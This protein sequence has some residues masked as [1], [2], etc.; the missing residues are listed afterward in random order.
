MDDRD[1]TWLH[2]VGTGKV[3]ENGRQIGVM[4]ESGE[5]AEAQVP[6]E[7]EMHIGAFKG[8]CSGVE[9]CIMRYDNCTAYVYRALSSV[10]Y[11]VSENWGNSLCATELGTGVN[12]QGRLPQ[13][14]YGPAADGR[15]KCKMQILV[16]DAVTAPRR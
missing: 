7:K 8:H 5:S 2:P 13:D 9:E 1:V 11:W 12:K 6:P 16:N 10:R 15:G 14:R 3:F 4:V